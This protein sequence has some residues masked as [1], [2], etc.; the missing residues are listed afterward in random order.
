M[1]SKRQKLTRATFPKHNDSK[2]SWT[3]VVLRIQLH[4]PRSPLLEQPLFAVVS[5]KRLAKL[6]VERNAFKRNVFSAIEHNTSSFMQLAKGKYVITPTKA[7]TLISKEH[8]AKDIE[9]YL[10]R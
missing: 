2:T 1:I 7:T 3:G 5:P 6:A 10:S 4:V 9:A 8:I